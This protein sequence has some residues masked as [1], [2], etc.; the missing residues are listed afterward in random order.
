MNGKHHLNT[1]FT[2]LDL[3]ARILNLIPGDADI[4]VVFSSNNDFYSNI[5]FAHIANTIYLPVNKQELADIRT[6]FGAS[7]KPIRRS[8]TKEFY[9]FHIALTVNQDLTNVVEIVDLYA[10][11]LLA[12]SVAGRN[13]FRP[14]LDRQLHKL[15]DLI[16]QNSITDLNSFS[17][18]LSQTFNCSIH[19]FEIIGKQVAHVHTA[20]VRPH[21]CETQILRSK[22]TVSRILEAG[23]SRRTI[24]IPIFD[25]LRSTQTPRSEFQA[26]TTHLI[27]HHLYA[28]PIRSHTQFLIEVNQVIIVLPGPDR[29]RFSITELDAVEKMIDVFLVSSYRDAQHET[30]SWQTRE[31][32]SAASKRRHLGWKTTLQY[33]LKYADELGSRVVQATRSHSFAFL[34]YDVDRGCLRPLS[35]VEQEIDGEIRLLTDTEIKSIHK[36]LITLDL[37]TK[38]LSAFTFLHSPSHKSIYVKNVDQLDKWL[39]DAGLKGLSIRRSGHPEE[40]RGIVFEDSRAATEGAFQLDRRTRSEISLPI[41]VGGIPIGVI[42]LEAPSKHAY[43]ADVKYLEQVAANIALTFSAI[44]R[45]GDIS[46]LMTNLHVQEGLH[47][48]QKLVAALPEC[49]QRHDLRKVVDDLSIPKPTPARIINSSRFEELIQELLLEESIQS[50]KVDQEILRALK[51]RAFDDVKI[52]LLVAEGAVHIVRE[53]LRNLLAYAPKRHITIFTRHNWRGCGPS[54]VIRTV[55]DFPAPVEIIDQSF[56][57]P[58][59]L[60]DRWHFGLYLI[61]VITRSLSGRLGFDRQSGNSERIVEIVLPANK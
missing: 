36:E 61:G 21:P 20:Q 23:R 13:M 57:A 44:Q 17:D 35:I 26:D 59:K 54:V 2:R 30:I 34:L 60:H 50:D 43:D 9:S 42:N 15:R 58:L 16:R 45:S 33:L 10:S 56:Q 12:T 47:Q 3:V 55:I 46:W 28:M 11:M 1:P 19:L 40:H 52:E 25:H 38:F 18:H 51:F 5:S 39:F 8:V 24:E 29:H 41:R 31:L 32:Q 37:P 4:M 6:T 27:E 22:R 7:A 48:V 49:A 53:L 14:L